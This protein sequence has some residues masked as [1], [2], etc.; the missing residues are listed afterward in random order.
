MIGVIQW[1]ILEPGVV[2]CRAD[3]LNKRFQKNPVV[4]GSQFAMNERQRHT[5][6]HCPRGGRA[7]WLHM[8]ARSELSLVAGGQRR[9]RTPTTPMRPPSLANGES[10]GFRRLEGVTSSSSDRLPW[11]RLSRLKRQ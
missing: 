1:K 3:L 10:G 11:L 9:T 5:A 7:G 8:R 2:F 6:G 4:F